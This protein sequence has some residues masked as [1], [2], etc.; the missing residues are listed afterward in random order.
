MGAIRQM[1]GFVLSGSRNPYIG[2]KEYMIRFCQLVTGML[3]E[4]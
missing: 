2:Q 4:E 3:K 1:F